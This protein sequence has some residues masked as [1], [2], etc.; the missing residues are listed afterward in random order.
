[1]VIVTGASSGIGYERLA[2]NGCYCVFAYWAVME[3][4]ISNK[5]VERPSVINETRKVVSFCGFVGQ[6]S[7]RKPL[8]LCRAADSSRKTP[9]G[10][11]LENLA[12]MAFTRTTPRHG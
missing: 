10:T 11:S 1:M 8:A 3:K 4:S 6:A 12:G 5:M 9:I 7:G 2:R